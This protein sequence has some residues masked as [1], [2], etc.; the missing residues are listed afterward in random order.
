M[1]ATTPR[2]FCSPAGIAVLDLAG[3]R[4]DDARPD[5]DKKALRVV[6]GD[7]A[8]GLAH[9]GPDVT[10]VTERDALA[11]RLAHRHEQATRQ[12]LARDVADEEKDPIGVELEEVVEIAAHLSRRLEKGIEIEAR[13]PGEGAG[14]GRQ[15]AHLDAAR[16]LEV[17]SE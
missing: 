13:F 9:H 5:G 17:A 11:Q 7:L 6:P 8:V 15:A 1:P 12:P 4:V 14:R 10:V 3:H 16:G 2:I